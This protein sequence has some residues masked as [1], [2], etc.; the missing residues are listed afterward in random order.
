MIRSGDG[1]PVVAD[2]GVARDLSHSSSLTATG[3]AVGTPLYMAP[4]QA[5]GQRPVPASDVYALGMILYEGLAGRPPFGVE[6]GP[7]AV[8]EAIASETPQP[9]SAHGPGIPRA[10]DAV[11]LKAL[12]KEPAARY[13]DG[14]ALAATLEDWL[15]GRLPEPRRRAVWWLAG[16]AG[17]LVAG[18]AGL[19]LALAFRSRPETGPE[20]GA[21]H[22]G[23]SATLASAAG[24]AGSGDGGGADALETEGTTG[25]GRAGGAERATSEVA[26][27]AL[28]RLTLQPGPLLGKDT[29]LRCDGYYWND[30]QGL[31]ASLLIGDRETQRGDFRALLQFDLGTIP[32]G[33]EVRRASL[34]LWVDE[35]DQ[36]AGPITIEARALV[37]SGSRTPWIEGT[38]QVDERL[39]GVCWDGALPDG[40]YPGLSSRRPDLSQPDADERSD[41]C[42]GPNGVLAGVAS[43]WT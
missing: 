30:N 2:F 25:P 36:L 38:S 3:A 23:T 7:M 43:S 37:P 1:A 22:T 16:I 14:D 31:A 10:L 17:G 42:L 39:D 28:Q 29:F 8:Y 21:P 32:A 9:P 26:P 12:H 11:C 18:A 5:N 40:A 41:F 27:P 35:V 6:G 15:A 19:T 24:L 33:A 4:E 13:A 34:T 20:L